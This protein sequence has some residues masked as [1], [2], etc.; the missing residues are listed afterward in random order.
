MLG[1]ILN[2]LLFAVASWY[3][4]HRRI[5]YEEQL[6][7]KLFPTEYPSYISETIIGIPFIKSLMVKSS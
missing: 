3:F 5:P 7:L 6:L 4:F 2:S 1:N